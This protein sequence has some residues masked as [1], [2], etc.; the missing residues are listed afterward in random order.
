MKKDWEI[1]KLAE[2]CDFQNG[3]AF[4]SITYKETGLPI[5]R[6]TNIQN[7][8][9]EISDL[10]YFDTKDYKEN[11]ERFKVC[12]GDLVV[13]MSG[14]TTGKLGINN[15]DTIFYL[16]QRVGKFIPKKSIAKAFLYYFLSTKV[17][18]SLRIA[19]GAAQPNLSTEQINNFKIPLPPLPEQQRIVAILDEAFAAIAKAK[20]NAQQ[21][22]Q[23][24]KELFESYLQGVFENK[25]EGWEEKTLKDVTT[26]IGSGATPR[27]GNE[28]YKTE[29]IS[30][31][32][33][34]N[35][36]D[37]EFRERNLAFIDDKQA[38]ELNNVTLE[39]NDVLLNIT[40]ASVARC[41]IIPKEY[42]PARVNQHV[43][44]IRAKKDIIDTGFLNLLLTSKFYKD[45]LLFTG[46][47]GA[48]R[49]AITKAQLEVFR[50]TFP[51]SLKT[52]Q[53]IV[54]KLDALN[55][56]TKKLES[57]YQQKIKDLEE[58]KKS[59][60][61]KAFSGELKTTNEIAI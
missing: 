19:A 5:L 44:I 1:K 36:H 16:N 32:R 54:Q 50:I 20:A 42:L 57:I 59:V 7:Q 61:Q 25:G 38:K 29:G 6:I 3:F 58:L 2:V 33:S 15:S 41:C 11:F 49:Q 10:V 48:T 24:A 43:S 31:I 14:A 35:V 22:L 39:E 9:L 17:E 52:Q 40:G 30:L 34:M 53:T 12:K 27:G 28:S 55:A 46:E 13:A 37:F 56:E 47:Q 21:N 4:K 18:E 8:N 51:K 45:Q 26:K 60:L 23:N